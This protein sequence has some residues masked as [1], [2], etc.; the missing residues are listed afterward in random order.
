MNV[1]PC[2]D[3]VI[4]EKTLEE[5]TT[6]G[7]LARVEAGRNKPN[8]GTVVAV[9]PGRSDEKGGR[10]IM[11][12][13]VGDLVYYQARVGFDFEEEGVHYVIIREHDVLAVR[14]KPKK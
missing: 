4:V 3:N 10:L 9:G 1:K 7:G 6:A 2:R 12:S 13:K 8:E 11:D 14:P 5:E